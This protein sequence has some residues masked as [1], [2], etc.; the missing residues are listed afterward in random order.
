MLTYTTEVSDDEPGV[1]WRRK[2]S[3][4]AV[5][6]TCEDRREVK[7][8]PWNFPGQN[9]GMGSHSLLQGM[10]PTQGSN[11]GLPHCRKILH[12][13]SHHGSLRVLEWVAYPFSSGTSQSRNQTG[14]SCIAGGF[15]TSWAAE[16][17]GV[18]V[19]TERMI[20]SLNSTQLSCLKLF[21]LDIF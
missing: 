7:V 1:S 5:C 18:H 12:H 10:F 13:V 9:T 15:F 2:G 14:V 17:H 19:R 4:T 6:H 3:K 20:W 16:L 8:A 11:P 21:I